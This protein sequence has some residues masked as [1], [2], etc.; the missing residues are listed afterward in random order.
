MAD[1]VTLDTAVRAGTQLIRDG[2]VLGAA[3]FALYA[4]FK[5]WWVWGSEVIDLRRDR[6]EWKSIALRIS[7]ITDRMLNGGKGNESPQLPERK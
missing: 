6:D 1:P 2:G 5:R 4:S 7:G 3:V